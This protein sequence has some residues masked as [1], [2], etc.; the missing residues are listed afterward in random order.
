MKCECQPP[1]NVF[2][3]VCGGCLLALPGVEHDGRGRMLSQL[4]MSPMKSAQEMAEQKASE[5]IPECVPGWAGRRLTYRLGFEDGHASRD[6]EVK[7]LEERIKDLAH[8]LV[9]E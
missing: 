1:E 5:R 2:N 7:A 9:Q 8:P 4:K 6:A 3:G